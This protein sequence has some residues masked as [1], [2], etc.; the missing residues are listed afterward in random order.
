MD[1]R[2]QREV[3]M[4]GGKCADDRICAGGNKYILY[5]IGSVNITVINLTALHLKIALNMHKLPLFSL[6]YV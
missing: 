4:D 3:R 6:V 2:N 5:Q 1:L